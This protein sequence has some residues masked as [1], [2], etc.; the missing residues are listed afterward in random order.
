V[1]TPAGL[2]SG[3]LLDIRLTFGGTDASGSAPVISQIGQIEMLLGIK[4]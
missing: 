4:G 2:A 1:I 3:D